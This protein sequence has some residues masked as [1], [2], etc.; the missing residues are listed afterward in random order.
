MNETAPHTIQKSNNSDIAIEMINI[1]KE[2]PGI[3][4]NDNINL[5]IKRGS[6]HA[7][8]G[9][10]G[11]GKSTLM[12]ILFGIYKPTS[13][14]IMLDGTPILISGP[15]QA[16]DLGIGMVHQ[17]FKLVDNYT[18]FENII[19]GAEFERKGFIDRETSLAKIKLLQEKFG[20]KFDLNEKTADALVVTQQKI[21]ILKM[22]YRDAEI[23][24]FDEP[25]AVLT[26]QE[27]DE[28][29][30]ILEFLKQNGKTILFITHKLWEVMKVSD[31][32]TVIRHGKVVKHYENIEGVTTT[33]IANWM[34]GEN[35]VYAKNQNHFYSDDVILKLEN[36]FVG[37]KLKNLSFEIHSGE[38][39]AIAG[40]SGNGQRELEYILSGVKHPKEGSIFLKSRETL[41]LHD[42]THYSSKKKIQ[43]FISVIPED[44]HKHGLVLDFNVNENSIIRS[45]YKK[46]F[47][48]NFIIQK[49]EVKKFT[50]EIIETFDV[51]GSRNG[52]AAARS[53]SG[54]NQQKAIVGREMLTDHDLIVAVQPTRGLDVG[55][56]NM[57]HDELLRE[58]ANGKAILLI[59]YELDEIIA[60]ADTIAVMNKGEIVGI[61]N[62]NDFERK[63]IGLL[64]AGI[65]NTGELYDK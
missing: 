35:V 64:M 45:L 9:E 55:A 18:N 1:T 10:N 50:N 54:G 15:N 40:V 31:E 33:E 58:K 13:G 2:F 11:A 23:L 12:S 26:P 20:L 47:V 27:I 57:I 38:I 5:A 43:S 16:N 7:L 17:H 28:F 60:L 24:I 36:I 56:I 61:K 22:L 51:R 25:T 44:R 32:I 3:L 65:N 53:L 63:E 6:I 41:E 8:V 34:V 14:T 46:R 62:T 37:D 42:I 49:R 29:L 48:N 30:N 59:S 19:L 4:A 39:L 52:N 21:E